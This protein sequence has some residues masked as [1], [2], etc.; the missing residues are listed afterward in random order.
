MLEKV[1]LSEVG[2]KRIS[3]FSLGMKRRLIIA[4]ALVGKPEILVLDEPFIGIDPEGMSE[5]RLMLGRLSNEGMTMLVTSH[6]IP[7]LIKLASVFGVMCK[8]KFTGSIGNTELSATV[9][10]KTVFKTD[11]PQGLA[12][13]INSKFPQYFCENASGEIMIFEE[14][15]RSR[16]EEMRGTITARSIKDI[17]TE[18]MSEEEILRWKMNGHT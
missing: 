4:G 7:E 3:T 14:L 12:S 6:H 9:R 11:D 15:E 10:K 18:P 8:G 2:K 16:C 1:G 5:M 17:L 13:E